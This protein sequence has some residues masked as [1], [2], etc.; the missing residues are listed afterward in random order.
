MTSGGLPPVCVLAGG[1][2]TRL[3]DRTR[4]VPKAL[5]EVAGAPFAFH[6]LRL[7]RAHGARRVVMCV[8]HLGE[9]VEEAVGDGAAHGLEVVYSYD[10]PGA[11]GTAAALRAALPLAG[12]ELLV[13]YGDT[14]LRIDYADVADARRRSG[15][16]ALMTVL[17]NDGSLR[18]VSNAVLAQG[19]VV[20]HDKRTPT[21][22]MA[23]MDYGLGAF[24][25]E[26]VARSAASDLNDLYAELAE[27]GLLAGYEAT[28]R[29]Y[30]I[31]T[32]E[33]LAEADA[34]LRAEPAVSGPAAGSG[35]S[36]RSPT[37]HGR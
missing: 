27:R 11:A 37:G 29:F 33:S 22:D 31:G 19:R 32:P 17:R 26:A 18:H 14:Y 28:E 12:E 16:P 24:A 8:G 1:L 35:A 9:L 3:G 34:F 25:A 15:L 21:P 2:G 10:P 6:Q 13:L 7:L 20:R 36:S 30:E 23:W 4:E 5:V